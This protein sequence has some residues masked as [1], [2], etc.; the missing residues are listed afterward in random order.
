MV[1]ENDAECRRIAESA[2]EMATFLTE[3]EYIRRDSNT[4]WGRSP[5]TPTRPVPTNPAA[6]A[7]DTDIKNRLTPRSVKRNS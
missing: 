6:S 3:H 2:A 1:R 5:L 4:L 7:I